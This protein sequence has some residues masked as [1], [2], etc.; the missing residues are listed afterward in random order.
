M[1]KE[2]RERPRDGTFLIE[3]DSED[4]DRDDMNSSEMNFDG[5]T[6]ISSTAVCWPHLL[7]V[8]QEWASFSVKLFAVPD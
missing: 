2:Q 8:Q 1:S 5:I 4:K 7:S 6:R 3:G